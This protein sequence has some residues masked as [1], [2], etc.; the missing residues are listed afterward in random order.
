MQ[1]IVVGAFGGPEQLRLQDL[2]TPRGEV[3]VQV[4]WAGVNFVDLYQREG[5]YPG[6]SVPLTPGL[7]GSGRVV[8]AGADGPWRAG[9]RVAF[10]TGVQGS[11]AQ[12]VAVSA[13]HLVAVP[14]HIGLRDAAASLE[15]GLTAAMLID[16]VARMTAGDTVLVHAAA[17]GVGG[18]L[19]QRL[20]AR[21]HRV[22]GTASSAAKLDWLASVGI[23][24]VSYAQ[25]ADWVGE[26]MRLTDGAGVRVAFDSVGRSTFTDSLRAL[27]LRGHLVLYGAAS[28]QPEP[29][30]IPALMAR[31]LT[32]SRPRLPDYL[33]NP[34]VLRQRASEVFEALRTKAVQLR[35]DREFALADAA[36]AH[37]ALASRDTQGK[38]LLAVAPQLD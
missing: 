30:A 25:G 38:V 17:G 22:I 9:D 7:E 14:D 18:W 26:V 33:G 28:G 36:C 21:G 13:A 10:T 34:K 2:P 3:L 6:V 29:V 35:I 5:R 24:A 16:D 20:R 4:A 31:S 32:L 11:Y 12:Q 1:G 23:E 27:G 19:V 15:H 8:E 37:R